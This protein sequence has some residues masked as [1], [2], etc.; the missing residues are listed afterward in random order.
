[1][2]PSC[3]TPNRDIPNEKLRS[4]FVNSRMTSLY[5]EA[6]A[7]TSH[8]W[9]LRRR[10]NCYVTSYARFLPRVLLILRRHCLPGTV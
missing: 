3:L 10:S 8:R 6:S 9:G 1:M 5:V 4:D 2:L 7:G